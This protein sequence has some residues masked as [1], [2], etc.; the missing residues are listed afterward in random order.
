MGQVAQRAAGIPA[1]APVARLN[2]PSART[3][4]QMEEAQLAA[5]AWGPSPATRLGTPPA[6]PERP[7][8]FSTLRIQ[9]KLEISTPGDADEREA[10]EVADRVMR[11]PAPGSGLPGLQRTGGVRIQRACAACEGE[12]E[13]K[14][15]RRSA[16]PGHAMA[17]RVMRMP[18]TNTGHSGLHRTG[19]PQIQRACAACEGEEEKKIRRSPSPGA[20]LPGLAR[21]AP[22]VD[23][24]RG[25]QSLAPQER[26]FFEPRFG[27][28]FSRVRIHTGATADRAARSVGAL[29]YTRGRDIVFREGAYQP[30]TESGRRLMAHELTHVVQQSKN[31]TTSII[32]R[33]P[34][35]PGG[36]GWLEAGLATVLGGAAHVQIQQRLMLRGFVPELPIPRASK[37]HTASLGC[38]PASRIQG[39]AD[40]ARIA[41]PIKGVSEIKPIAIASSLG[42]LE[43]RHYRRR[44]TQSKQRLTG[45]G[46]CGRQTPGLDD[47]AFAATL[48]GIGAATRIGLV[49]GAIVGIEDFGPFSLDPTVNLRAREVGAGAIGY[50]CVSNGS[51]RRRRNRRNQRGNQRRNRT[52]RGNRNPRGG[53]RTPRR[54]PNRPNSRGT[55]PRAQGGVGAYNIGFGISI[56]SF[57]VGV[58][59]AGVGV[60]VGSTSVAAGTAGA[61]IS[62]GSNSAAA[63][64]AGAGISWLS[65]SAAVASAGAGASIES[66]TAAA[67]VAGAGESTITQAA[68]AGAAGAGTTRGS[69]VAVAGAAGTGEMTDVTGS[70]AGTV[71]SGRVEGASDSATQSGSA[72]TPA[73]E[74][75]PTQGDS[76][77]SRGDAPTTRAGG[78]TTPGTGSTTG[79]PTGS[80]AAGPTTGPAGADSAAGSPTGPGEGSPTTDPA[81]ADSTDGGPTGTAAGGPTPGPAGVDSAAGGPTGTGRTSSPTGT[82]AA[83]GGAL[84]VLPVFPLGASEADRTRVAEEANRVALLL[85]R[86]N[87]AQ[88]ELMRQLASSSPTGQYLVPTSQWVSTI[89]SATEGLTIEELAYLRTI[90]WRPGHVTPAELRRSILR[91]LAHR[92]QGGSTTGSARGSSTQ[93]QSPRSRSGVGSSSRRSD[94]AAGGSAEG[95]GTRVEGSTERSGPRTR[96]DRATRP[97]PGTS[98]AVTGD[99]RFL[100]L[101]GLSATGDYHR[102]DAV[103]CT[104]RIVEATRQFELSGVSI[105]YL[106]RTDQESAGRILTSFR[107]YFTHD[108][109]SET[110]RFHGIGGSEHPMVYEFPSRAR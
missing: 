62:V 51:R 42:K 100:I 4:S 66:Q 76:A 75:S 21:A 97:P 89:M 28:D 27:L 79:R 40:I 98:R 83:A 86:A 19:G 9:P 32:Q 37:T 110:F 94:A 54:T 67:G 30:A 63:G 60:S 41:G 99:Y 96:T 7:I 105:T 55:R 91:V 93:S 45:T 25:G 107:V 23:A 103:V 61:G 16:V 104:I 74:G 8:D 80:G 87:P 70:A 53:N 18:E 57:N 5:P 35:G 84:G 26:A 44:A 81:G 72:Q 20:S 31:P 78:G 11:M 1:M 106:D 39:F 47:V 68:A 48:G 33:R 65:D 50:W 12:E 58:G 77:A 102:G 10:D 95:S 56:F 17:D 43:A 46:A 15:L 85:Q 64:S 92:R 38:Q 14:K 34:T 59:N 108:F 109:W 52:P 90:E 24:V 88:V 2:P 49:S 101:S 73:A 69:S 71:G 3:M 22:Q 29:A 13:G 82:S 6:P 36:C